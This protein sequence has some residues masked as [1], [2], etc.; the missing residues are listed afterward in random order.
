M[1]GFGDAVAASLAAQGIQV[2]LRALGVRDELIEHGSQAEWRA[3]LGL[4]AAGIERTV[5]ELLG[6]Q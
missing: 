3:E 2:P 6:R 4:D 5:R 1:G